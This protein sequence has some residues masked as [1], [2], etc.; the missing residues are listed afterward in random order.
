MMRKVLFAASCLLAPGIAVADVD[1]MLGGSVSLNWS[2]NSSSP[3]FNTLNTAGA[4]LTAVGGL[5]DTDE[6]AGASRVL[7]GGLSTTASIDIAGLTWL[8]GM[9]L[10]LDATGGTVTFDR[11]VL[12]VGSALGEAFYREGGARADYFGYADDLAASGAGVS[13]KLFDHEFAGDFSGDEIGHHLS[14]G[15]LDAELA[16]DLDHRSFAGQMSY[17]IGFVGYDFTLGLHA[18][19]NP[20]E[21]GVLELMA[22]DYY[23]IAGNAAANFGDISVGLS[24]GQERLSNWMLQFAGD[25]TDVKRQFVSLGASYTA[26]DALTLSFDVD[27]TVVS[28]EWGCTS[29]ETECLS[30]STTPTS[31][32]YFDAGI[33]GTFGRSAEVSTAF[34]IGAEY[35]V[36]K[37]VSLGGFFRQVNGVNTL[38]LDNTD[39]IGL[40]RG[41]KHSDGQTFGMTAS[42]SF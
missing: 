31:P 6:L 21:D 41:F 32:A 29:L 18:V 27:R 34:S 15:D 1:V 36:S 3:V 42:I 40:Q 8:G 30:G 39:A 4:A 24:L 13:T 37:N 17:N 2:D 35:H 23:G 7:S 9:D 26:I 28:A 33:G 10:G 14:F 25:E 12:S 20:I 11:G 38:A 16:Y 5:G 22:D 19:S